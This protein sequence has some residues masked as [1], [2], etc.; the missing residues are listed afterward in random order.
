MFDCADHMVKL[1]IILQLLHDTKLML[2][3]TKYLK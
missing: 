2:M 1:Y 3:N